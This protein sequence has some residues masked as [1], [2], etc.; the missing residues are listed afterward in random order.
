MNIKELLGKR[1]KTLRAEFKLSQEQV[2]QKL[3]VSVRHIQNIEYGQ[4]DIPITKLQLLAD[5]FKTTV[6]NLVDYSNFERI[7]NC[8][9]DEL[10]VGVHMSNA[11]GKIIFSNDT[12]TRLHGYTKEEVWGKKYIWDFISSNSAKE[13][14][15]SY[16]TYLRTERPE[17]KSYVHKLITKDGKNREFVH[18]WKYI[19]NRDREVIGFLTSFSPTS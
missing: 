9:F 16:L 17:P 5:L 7:S 2:A 8:P 12:S 18:D 4:V 19:H 13:D 10:P 15:Q 14:M 1:I 3:E 11:E 6:S